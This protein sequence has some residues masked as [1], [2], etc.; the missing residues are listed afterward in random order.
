MPVAVSAVASPAGMVAAGEHGTGVLTMSVPR[1]EKASAL[2][3]FWGIAEE[4]AASNGMKVARSEWRVVL[5]VHLADSRKEALRQIQERGG[6]YRI[7]YSEGAIGIFP[8]SGMSVESAAATLAEEGD[9][10]IGTPDDLIAKIHALQDYTGGFGRLLV[11]AIDWAETEHLIRSYE[12]IARYVMPE[13][14]G[15]LSG[16]QASFQD[17]ASVTAETRALRAEAEAKARDDYA[18]QQNAGR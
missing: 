14:Q 15:S 7:D 12:L 10:C 16:L 18:A 9:W 17:V 13:F 11:Q 2:R 8:P 1:G 3:D 4:S 6:R 5:H